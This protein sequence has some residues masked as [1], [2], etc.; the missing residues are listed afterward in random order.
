LQYEK[1]NKIEGYETVAAKNPTSKNVVISE[2]EQIYIYSLQLFLE[3]KVTRQ[4]LPYSMCPVHKT[5]TA[6][7]KYKIKEN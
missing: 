7:Q 3:A 4:K 1:H 5:I 2:K 6:M